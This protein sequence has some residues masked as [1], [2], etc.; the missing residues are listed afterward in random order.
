MIKSNPVSVILKSV[1]I[2]AL[3]LSKYGLC[4][5]GNASYPCSNVTSYEGKW[6]LTKAYENGTMVSTPRIDDVIF[7]F[8]EFKKGASNYSLSI[9]ADN[10]F[11]TSFNI[12]GQTKRKC[13]DQIDMGPVMST[14]KAPAENFV[15]IETFLSNNLEKMT[16]IKQFEEEGGLTLIMKAKHA[17]IVCKYVPSPRTNYEGKWKIMSAFSEN[18]VAVSLSPDD[19]VIIDIL[20]D[21]KNPSKYSWSIKADNTFL[22][23]VEIIGHDGS[24]DVIE[25][26]LSVPTTRKMPDP[27]FE[28]IE[29]FI[30][31]DLKNMRRMKIS[32]NGKTGD[33]ILSMRAG[34]GI[35]LKCKK[36]V[37]T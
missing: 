24:V 29:T 28:A 10:T 4:Q 21:E 7:D 19:D 35:K 1:P 11:A 6:K 8:Q 36:L 23:E 17:K 20:P 3:L 25:V 12:T 9:E 5:D 2:V 26:G 30:R 31:T 18:G 14:R 34:N 13:Y 15:Q 37:S 16:K 32:K 27:K 22:T 33:E